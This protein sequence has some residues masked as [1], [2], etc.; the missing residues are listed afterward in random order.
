MIGFILICGMFFISSP[1]ISGKTSSKKYGYTGVKV[2][3]ECHAEDAIGNQ[4]KIWSGSP[5]ARA[6]L[7]LKGEKAAEI[8]ESAG[9]NSPAES[10]ECLK[11][12]TTGGG[13]YPSVAKEGVGCEACHG[14]VKNIILQA[15]MLITPAGRTVIKKLL[16]S[17]CIRYWG[18]LR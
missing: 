14:P 17:G 4:N 3:G 10:K 16:N 13:E 5:H 1:H 11:C 12:H 6:Y 9:I 15:A 2:C 8:A 18:L 7:T